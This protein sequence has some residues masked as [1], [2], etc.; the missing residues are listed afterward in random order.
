MVNEVKKPETKDK[1]THS[2]EEIKE[3]SSAP[4]PSTNTGLGCFRNMIIVT[5]LVILYYSYNLVNVYMDKIVTNPNSEK[6]LKAERV[7]VTESQ[8]KTDNE[9][10]IEKEKDIKDNE[11]QFEEKQIIPD[12]EKQK[13]KNYEQRVKSSNKTE[14]VEGEDE[15][16]FEDVEIEVDEY[17]KDPVV[18]RTADN[19]EFYAEVLSDTPHIR[20]FHN[21][22]LKGEA[23]HVI[24]LA[25]GRFVPSMIVKKGSDE[26]VYDESRS[27]ISAFLDHR[28]DEVT[29]R[30]EDR[31]CKLLG[32]RY[33]HLEK[34]QVLQYKKGN[35][36]D[37]HYDWFSDKFRASMD[38][39]P[40]R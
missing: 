26:P 30:I 20:I 24:K 10:Q 33:S 25:Q 7:L 32:I 2:S 31:I 5:S 1:S 4:K 13:V 28:E 34:F 21:F 11:K 23:E 38:N 19:E 8:I 18:N 35:K 15:D 14:R 27:S 17:Y 6:D 29:R 3:G 16:E 22:L 36:F 9:M 12:S 37:S 39:M 40:Q